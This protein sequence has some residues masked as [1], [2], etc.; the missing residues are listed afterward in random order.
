MTIPLNLYMTLA[1]EGKIEEAE[2]GLAALKP[3]LDRIAPGEVYVQ[4]YLSLVSGI[5][6]LRRGNASTAE[7]EIREALSVYQHAVQP[8]HVYIAEAQ[9]WLASALE[10]QKRIAEARA[11]ANDSVQ[12]WSRNYQA[13]NPVLEEARDYLNKLQQ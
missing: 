2:R 7:H 9:R 13:G 11:A 4:G 3:N 5:C 12:V 10:A 1:R 8:G 6:A